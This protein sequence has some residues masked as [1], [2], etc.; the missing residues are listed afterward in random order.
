MLHPKDGLFFMA[1]RRLFSERK[2]NF[3]LHFSAYEIYRNTLFDI[4]NN[5]RKVIACEQADGSVK[6]MGLKEIN[7]AGLTIDN[8]VAMI[9]DGLERRSVGTWN[10]SD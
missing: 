8:V 4:L 10:L 3:A 1:L 7:S 9:N 5:K 6:I 2:N